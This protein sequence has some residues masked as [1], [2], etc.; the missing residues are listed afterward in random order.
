MKYSPQIVS[1]IIEVLNEGEGR[2]NAC[3]AAG[4]HYSTFIEWMGKTEFSEAVKKAESVGMDQVKDR[5]KKAI[6]DKFTS[7]WQAAAWWLERNYPEEFKIRTE[8]T[9]KDDRFAGWT[10]EEL[11]E[12]A[13]TG[14]RPDRGSQ[15]G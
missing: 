10:R 14:K 2:V 11:Q 3:K 15:Q 6:I 5:A 1:V 12:Y 13:R 9:E 7:Q 8:V 4:I